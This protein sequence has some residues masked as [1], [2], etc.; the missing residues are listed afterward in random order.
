MSHPDETMRPD[1]ETLDV[2]Q[3]CGLGLGS[4]IA[5]RFAGVG[6]EFEILEWRRHVVE[7]MQFAEGDLSDAGGAEGAP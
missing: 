3:D 1:G 6:L 7:P 5:A 4:G 2:R